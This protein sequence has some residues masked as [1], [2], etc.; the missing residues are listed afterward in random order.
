[1]SL[2]LALL[3]QVLFIEMLMLLVSIDLRRRFATYRIANARSSQNSFVWFPL[4]Y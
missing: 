1:M 4:K 3:R 2:M